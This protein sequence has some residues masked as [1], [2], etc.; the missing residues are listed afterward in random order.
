MEERTKAL[1]DRME[2]H[3]EKQENDMS[4]IWEAINGLRNRLPTWAVFVISV[5][6]AVLGWIT[7]ATFH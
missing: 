2:R 5:L 6:T 7:R 4:D 3:E 1:T